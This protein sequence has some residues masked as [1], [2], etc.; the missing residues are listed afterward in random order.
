MSKSFKIKQQKKKTKSNLKLGPMLISGFVVFALLCTLA[1]TSLGNWIDN[2]PS[3]GTSTTPSPG[4]DESAEVVFED[5]N[6]KEFI[7][8]KLSLST[9]NVTENQV[10]TVTSLSISGVEHITSLKGL[11]QFPSITTLTINN[12]KIDD[13]SALADVSTLTSI[14]LYSC[15]LSETKCE[16]ELKNITKIYMNDSVPNTAILQK[17]TSAATV[18]VNNCDVEDFTPFAGMS[19]VK[20]INFT[21]VDS[22]KSFDGIGEIENLEVLS[23]TTCKLEKL[24]GID[25]ASSLVQ[26]TCKQS[27]IADM[28]AVAGA[29]KLN[30]L[31]MTGSAVTN[32]LD[33]IGDMPSLTALDIEDLNGGKADVSFVSN[34]KTLESLCMNGIEL[35]NLDMVSG[36]ENLTKLYAQD[37]G[38]TNISALSSLVNIEDLRISDNAIKDIAAL[39]SLKNLE[40]LYIARN[41]LNSIKDISNTY[42]LEYLDISGNSGITA[43][44]SIDNWWL[45]SDLY[46]SGCSIAK[47]ELGNCT[48]LAR[49]DLSGNKIEDISSIATLAQAVSINISDNLIKEL[50]VMATMSGLKTFIAFGNEIVNVENIAKQTSLTELNMSDNA[51][52]D[53]SSLEKLTSL[54]TLNLSSNKISDV[55]KLAALTKL[56]TLKLNS[57]EIEKISDLNA[58]KSLTTLWLADNKIEDIS[59]LTALTSLKEFDISGNNISDIS[60]VEKFT[61]L[62]T[63]NASSNEIED[64]SALDNLSALTT[65][66]LSD[67]KIE[68]ISPLRSKT[69]ID[70]LNLANNNISD[71]KDV[72]I[73][74]RF[75]TFLDL[76]NNHI[77][78]ISS[79]NACTSLEELILSGNNITDYSPID[80]LDIEKVVK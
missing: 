77:T 13:L 38:L 75:M 26:L 76:S 15:D 51:I 19:A 62:I 61:S 78:D 1:I 33:K 69:S 12:V 60:V 21:N 67:N 28:S 25:K 56:T 6:F 2:R 39:A 9:D 53:V 36:L 18:D 45:L 3:S 5:E 72:F 7:K 54:T 74:F 29:A 20:T 22:M 47:V 8:K 58:L 64:I 49:I 66:D 63:L 14:F 80:E 59:G 79:L 71:L 57:N 48:E 31:Y 44:D 4:P 55:A 40:K 35:G 10:K 65:V 27:E 37:C 23:F 34:I 42:S 32:G 11:E 70:E 43:I 30:T 52:E 24:D 16:Q 17:M 68:D 46:A 41:D 73:S 50:P